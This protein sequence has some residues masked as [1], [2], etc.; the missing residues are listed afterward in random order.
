V[1]GHQRKGV[2]GKASVKGAVEGHQWKG[3]SGE[4]KVTK[5]F[6]Q[7][8]AYFEGFSITRLY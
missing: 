6:Q 1:E 3:G 8:R 2:N 4:A 5:Q 7:Y